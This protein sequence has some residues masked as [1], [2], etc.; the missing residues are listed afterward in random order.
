MAKKKTKKKDKNKNK[1]EYSNEIVGVIIILF[2][3][4]GLL[5]TGIVGNMVKSF[6]IFLVG[7]I[8]VLLLLLLIIAGV[9]L[10]LKKEPPN[11]LSSR[12]IG[13]YIII[14]SFLVLLHVRYIEVNGTHGVKIIT[15]TFDNLMLS[16]TSSSALS[17]S[18]GGIVGAIFSY[19]FV[20]AF[21]DGASI[22][23]C[24]MFVLGAILLLNVSLLDLYNK[25][26][27]HIVNAF[28]RDDEEDENE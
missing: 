23:V 18:G 6:A 13:L 28:N 26:K 22:V 8:Y 3:I 17:N 9:L 19:L 4:I 10:I 20:S 27:P 12:L 5:G 16:F 14:I 7:T 21:G 15:E 25:I 11:L 2:G 1:F 24:T